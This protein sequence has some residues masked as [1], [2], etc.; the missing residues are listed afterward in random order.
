MIAAGLHGGVLTPAGLQMHAVLA[1]HACEWRRLLAVSG[2]A[3]YNVLDHGS[4]TSKAQ[5]KM[6]MPAV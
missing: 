4:S 6:Q 3:A 2:T 5:G 1:R